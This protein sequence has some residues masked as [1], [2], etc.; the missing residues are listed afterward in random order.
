MYYTFKLSQSLCWNQIFWI[1][2]LDISRHI[3][4]FKVIK[5]NSVIILIS[6]IYIIF[7]LLLQILY[8]T[9]DI[10]LLSLLFFQL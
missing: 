6:G 1:L 9:Y 7:K 2:G 5:K 4:R 3:N 8:N 10:H